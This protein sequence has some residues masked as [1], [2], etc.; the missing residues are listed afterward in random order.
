MGVSKI[1]PTAAVV[2]GPAGEGAPEHAGQ[3]G[4]HGQPT[5]RFSDQ[6]FEKVGYFG[7]EPG[8]FQDHTGQNEKWYG[9]EG[10][11]SNTV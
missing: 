9:Q 3:H 7:S 8:L 10:E 5:D 4:H 2:A 6:E 11:G 1:K